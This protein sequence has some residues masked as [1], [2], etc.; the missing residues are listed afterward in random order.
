MPRRREDIRH[1]LLRKGFQESNS[2]HWKFVYYNLY[3]QKT[4]IFT[5]ISYGSKHK[6]VSDDNLG[7]MAKQCRLSRG[8]FDDLLDCPLSREE[9]ERKLQEKGFF[10]P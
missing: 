2:D 4:S 5:K 6:D 1:G 10:K 3:G 7:K 9:Y 8:E